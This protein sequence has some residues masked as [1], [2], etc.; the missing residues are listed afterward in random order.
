MD[1]LIGSV[2]IDEAELPAVSD[3]T[4]P[5]EPSVG[6]MPCPHCRAGSFRRSSRMITP[7]LRE[8]FYACR[9]IACGHTWK[10]SLIF[11]YSLSP[12]AIPDPGLNLPLRPLP[13]DQAVMPDPA[14]VS[15]PNQPGLFDV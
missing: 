2:M 12:S 14:M 7:M 4:M 11:E 6:E 9:N 8:V 15:D 3:L 5:G 10:A 1:G 13:R